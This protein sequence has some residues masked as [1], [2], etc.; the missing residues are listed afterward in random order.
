MSDVSIGGNAELIHTRAPM[1]ADDIVTLDPKDFV[2]GSNYP[3]VSNVC[4]VQW[5]DKLIGAFQV[6]IVDEN[7]AILHIQGSGLKVVHQTGF[8]VVQLPNAFNKCMFLIW[9]IDNNRV[10][11]NAIENSQHHWHQ[12]RRAKRHQ[13]TLQAAPS[14]RPQGAKHYNQHYR[15]ERH[16]IAIQ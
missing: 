7:T 1:A 16:S 5:R 2:I 10:V 15:A 13:W 8:F 4:V 9:T 12:T 6:E 3:A 14:R 11:Y